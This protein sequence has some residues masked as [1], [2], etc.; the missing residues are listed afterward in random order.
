[1]S[2]SSPSP[3][4][5][6]SVR[7]PYYS[8][9]ET[10]TSERD[11]YRRPAFTFG[12]RL[13]RFSWNFARLL[14]Y[15]PTPRPMHAWRSAVLRLFGAEIGP[16]C[17][18]YPAARIWAPWNLRAADHVTVADGAEV[19]NPAPVILGS[20]VIISQDAYLCGATHDYDDAAF[21]LIAFSM[22]VGAYAWV[23]AR[24]SVSPGVTI[25]EGAVLGLGSIATR[26]LEP[27]T[28]YAGVPARRIKAREHPAAPPSE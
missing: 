9:A 7:Q 16:G 11:P 1:M 6:S 20:R 21:P 10:I 22:E 2:T 26:T 3:T 12:N 27:W 24:A 8:A 5:Q 13:R 15:R 4:P 17:H 28:V 25:G 23:C 19:Y 14:L 18:F